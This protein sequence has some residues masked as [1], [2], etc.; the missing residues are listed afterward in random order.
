MYQAA[1]LPT[2]LANLAAVTDFLQTK[3]LAI[4]LRCAAQ[5][6]FKAY[7]A[8]GNYLGIRPVKLSNRSLLWP[9]KDVARVLAG[10]AQ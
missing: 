4:Y 2:T 5:T 8:T 1:P 10:G 7:S 9:I 6:I 3:E